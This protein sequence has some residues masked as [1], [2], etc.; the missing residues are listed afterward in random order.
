MKK[1]CCIAVAWVALAIVGCGK[2]SITE[3][4]STTVNDYSEISFDRTVSV[5][6]TSSSEVSVSGAGSGQSVSI[7]SSS[8]GVTIVNSGSEKVKYELSGTT[9]NGYFKVYSA[10]LQAILLNGA[11]ITNPEGAAINVQGPQDSPSDGETAYI[12]LNGTNALADGSSYAATIDGEDMKGVLFAEG[13]L[14][15]SGNGSLTVKASGKSG[16][17]SDDYVKVLNG[18]ISVVST[19]STTVNGTDTTKVSGI[20]AKDG[21]VISDGEVSLT[22][23]GTGSK[24]ISGD[25]TATFSGGTVRVAVSGSNFGSSSGGG[26]GFGGGGH[27]KS[28]SG[29]PAKGIKFDGDITISGG[30]VEVTCTSHEG[31]ESKGTITISGGHVYSYSAADDAINSGSDLTIS[32]G[33]VCAYATSNDG[34]DANGNCYINGGVV[35]AIGASSPEVAVDA[36]TEGGYKLYVNGGTLIAIGGLERGSSL[37]QSCY[38]SNSWSSNTWY[39]LTV[40]SSVYAFKTPSGGGSGLV[41][42]GSSTPSLMKGVTISDGTSYFNGMFRVGATVSGGSA[43]SL[44]SYSGNS[45]GGGARF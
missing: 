22:C 35:Y 36:N 15:F 18:T 13:S 4:S 14:I 23:S 20:K 43:V 42:S 1:E 33:Y 37:S 28:S 25:G 39:S 11:N 19:S 10:T 8:G 30:T 17:V 6:W 44:S 16:I 34:L 32:D 27:R 9:D 7:S 21:F 24:G 29:V 45:G 38:S 12:V 5:V 2:D 26:N 31:I 40:G 3:V 41:V